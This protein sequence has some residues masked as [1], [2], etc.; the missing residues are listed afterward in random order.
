MDVN[1]QAQL[2]SVFEICKEKYTD[3]VLPILK[4]ALASAGFETADRHLVYGWAEEISA[5]I[6]PQA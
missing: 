4:E 3:D 6:R 5:G 1:L 2:D